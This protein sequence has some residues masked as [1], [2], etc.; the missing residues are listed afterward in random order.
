MLAQ[1]LLFAA[2]VSAHAVMQAPDP[3]RTGPAQEALCGAAV[4]KRL[5]NDRA[6]PIENA[7][8]Y[9]DADYKCDAYMCRGYQLEDNLDNVQVFGAGDELAVHIDLI[10][11]HRPGYANISVI[12]LAANQIIGEPLKS[13][14]DWLSKDPDA[15]GDER[16]F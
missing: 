15:P 1:S 14:D 16:M 10:A 7:M 5:E 8:E 11:G 12:D 6:G 9:A 3:R 13:W 4:T 2:G